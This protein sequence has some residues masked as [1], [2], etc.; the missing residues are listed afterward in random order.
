MA[1]LHLRMLLTAT[2]AMTATATIACDCSFVERHGFLHT[3]EMGTIVVPANAIGV[4]FKEPPATPERPD[5][6]PLDAADFVIVDDTAQILPHKAVV[7]RVRSALVPQS[8]DRRAGLFRVAPA[9][10]FIYGHRYMFFYKHAASLPTRGD[11]RVLAS[12][13][14]AVSA[15]DRIEL[16][17]D[18]APVRQFL[19]LPGGSM[20]SRSA[21]AVVQ[22]VKYRLPAGREAYRHLLFASTAQRRLSADGST[23]GAF[24]PMSYSDSVCDPAPEPGASRF[25]L[26]R[27]LVYQECPS[28]LD[29]YPRHQ[30]QGSASMLELEDTV[31]RTQI[32]EL[33]FTK[34]RGPYCW[35]LRMQQQ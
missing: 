22:M 26:G 14:V 23:P 1:A 21:A 9:G 30:V 29:K 24:E 13:P 6:Q 17:L 27:E 33:P 10:G 11:V 32:L 18:G 12:T 20:C 35:L 3:N 28:L 34:A 5:R 16:A 19:S 31:H 7:S 15:S 2:L 8:Q 4:L 25:G